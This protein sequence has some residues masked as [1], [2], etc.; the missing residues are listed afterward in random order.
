MGMLPIR[1]DK[2]LEQE[3]VFPGA[4]LVRAEGDIKAIIVDLADVGSI[5][6]PI[7]VM[8]SEKTMV[9]AEKEGKLPSKASDYVLVRIED[10]E[11]KEW[12]MV[13]KGNHVMRL[14]E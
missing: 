11:T 3:E 6:G 13:T 9:R 4:F 5:G 8:V 10:K 7:V 12:I 2:A 1:L 14:V